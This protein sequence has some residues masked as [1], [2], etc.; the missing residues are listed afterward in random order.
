MR[1]RTAPHRSVPHHVASHYM[2]CV[3]G[4]APYRVVQKV[5]DGSCGM[6]FVRWTLD[7]G[8]RSLGWA[9]VFWRSLGGSRY[10]SVT[11]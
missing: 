1:D 10:I 3:V 9:K 4:A 7:T 5:H 8:A 2:S 6:P 11:P